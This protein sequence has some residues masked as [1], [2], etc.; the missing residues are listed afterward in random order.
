MQF[1]Q[2]SSPHF[3]ALSLLLSSNVIPDHIPALVD[4]HTLE[5]DSTFPYTFSPQIHC[6]DGI[7]P[8]A[9]HSLLHI[10]KEQNE[11]GNAKSVFSMTCSYQELFK[12]SGGQL[13]AAC[14]YLSYSFQ[15]TML[16]F[17]EK[18]SMPSFPHNRLHVSNVSPLSSS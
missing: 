12:T 5:M 15:K 7:I 17:C 10:S 2:P 8:H 14:H 16:L 11:D 4:K 3:L 6:P 9:H 13:P 18:H 1:K